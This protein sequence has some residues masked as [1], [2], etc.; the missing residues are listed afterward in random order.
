M[1]KFFNL[2]FTDIAGAIVSTILVAVI[3]Y[4]LDVGDIFS[5]DPKELINIAVL[6]GLGSLVK[7]LGTNS[8]GKFAGAIKVK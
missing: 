4:V 2:N 8:N 6:A 7:S 1:S 3:G 5:L